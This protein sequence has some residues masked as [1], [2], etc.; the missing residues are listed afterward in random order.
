MR[1]AP[2]TAATPLAVVPAGV[3]VLVSCQQRGDEVVVDPYRNP[4]WA[5]LPQFGGYMTNIYVNS[6]DNKLP[7]IPDC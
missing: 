1:S 2:T 4:W 7:G 5:Y 3:D 6:P